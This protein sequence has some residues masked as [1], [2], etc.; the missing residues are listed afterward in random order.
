MKSMSKDRK[1]EKRSATSITLP[2]PPLKT[3]TVVVS[4]LVST[5]ADLKEP[6]VAAGPSSPPSVNA[7]S[8]SSN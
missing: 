2:P 8:D 7:K 6:L 1:E 5:A 3:N 4:G